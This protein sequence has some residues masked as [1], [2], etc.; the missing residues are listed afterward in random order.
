M[1]EPQTYKEKLLPREGE[2]KAEYLARINASLA[3]PGLDRKGKAL[4]LAGKAIGIAWNELDGM[5]N[6]FTT[7]AMDDVNTPRETIE[8]AT[9][10]MAEHLRKKVL[11]ELD[12]LKDPKDEIQ[13]AIGKHGKGIGG[14]AAKQV[15]AVVGKQVRAIHDKK[16]IDILSKVKEPFDAM[17]DA[18]K[19]LELQPGTPE[20]TIVKAL[21]PLYRDFKEIRRNLIDASK[22]K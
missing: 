18:V 10:L 22:G 3:A 6:P 9:T 5:P 7:E 14:A 11:P 15:A 21:T 4:L 13:A 20:E 16:V 8:T 17:M 2:E 12:A 1:A 19:T